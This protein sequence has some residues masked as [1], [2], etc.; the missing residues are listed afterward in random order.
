MCFLCSAT[1]TFDPGRHP[2]EGPDGGDPSLATIFESGDAAASTGTSATMSVGDTFSGSLGFVGDRDWVAVNLTSG[3]NYEVALSSFSADTYLRIYDS[4]GSLIYFND[5]INYPSNTNSFVSFIAGYSGTFYVAAGSFNDAGTGSYTMSVTEAAAP[6]PATLDE[7]ANYLTDGYWNFNGASG[8]SFDTSSSNVITVNLTGLT[9]DGLALARWALEVWEAVVDLEFVET[10]GS[11]DITFDDNDSGAYATTSTSGG[12]IISSD[13]NVSTAW[14]SNSGTQIG[15]YSLQTYIHEIG[16]ALGLGHQGGYNGSA[17]YGID[18]TFSNDS[19]QMSIM[20][21]FSQTENTST[22]ASFAY[23]VSLMMAD[24]VAGQNLY[25]ASTATNGNTTWGANTNLGGYW[26][27]LFGEVFDGVNNSSVANNAV[28]FTIFD[29]GGTDTFDLSPATTNNRI[30]M[31]GGYFSN[32]AGGTGNV[33]IAEGTVLENLISGSGNDTITGNDADNEITGGGGND[34]I[35]GGAGSDTAVINATLASVTVTD[36]GGGSVRITSSDGTD[37]FDNFEFFRFSSGTVTLAV[38]LGGSPAPTT[39]DD[40]IDGTSTPDTIDGLA[41]NDTI[42]GLGGAD[43]LLGN[44]GDDSL[45]GSAG[46]D[47]ISGGG[48]AD[49]IY[50]GSDDD[51]LLGGNGADTMSGGFNNDTVDGGIG[52]DL[53]RGNGGNDTLLG[54]EGRDTLIGGNGNDR[55]D[56]GEDNDRLD[57]GT[58]SDTLYG[59]DGDDILL[60][61]GGADHLYGG[62]GNDTGEGGNGNDRFFGGGGNDVFSG[63]GGNDRAYGENNND[64]LR[65]GGGDD[66]LVGG[67]GFDTLDGGLDNDELTGGGNADVFVFADGHGDDTI[68][69]FNATNGN[70]DIDFSSVSAITDIA[71][72]LANHIVSTAGG[73]VVID[74]GGG[75]SLTL[76]GVDVADL[77]ANDFIF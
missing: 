2:G 40:V 53:L 5:D 64:S 76:L 49:R 77:G 66:T 63:D 67:S 24:I 65:G 46:N 47:T 17:T 13:I 8:R 57:G 56:G 37:V 73:N 75:N 7:L 15:T 38:L 27:T 36:L 26:A 54:D 6:T 51:R 25:G 48:G 33:G 52:N 68:T 60:G 23:I 28:A 61:G 9:A 10:S 30:D 39:G 74:T 1:S 14:L 55:L 11:A 18:E 22:N 20:S 34:S 3:S 35:D 42:T 12:N 29:N 59:R 72:L 16:H 45:L 41:G 71:D 43:S 21:Y 62:D 31:R 44:A 19:W 70:E 69:D 58:R 50:G 4:S 32:I